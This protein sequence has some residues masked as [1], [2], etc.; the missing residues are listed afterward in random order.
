MS[1]TQ[2]PIP[3]SLLCLTAAPLLTASQPAADSLQWRSTAGGGLVV[4]AGGVVV[5]VDGESGCVC[6]VAHGGVEL[7]SSSI[8]AQLPL[9]FCMGCKTVC[10]NVADFTRQTGRTNADALHK[11]K[12]ITKPHD[13][14]TSTP[15]A[16]IRTHLPSQSPAC[17]GPPLTTTAGAARGRATRPGGVPQAFTRC[18][19]CAPP[20]CC[21]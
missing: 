16:R 5:E 6:R 4:D 7:L 13:Q 15:H 21:G 8:G 9:R 17:T 2:L 20:Q 19:A 14:T 12:S 10:G 1:A 3:P 11:L 18:A